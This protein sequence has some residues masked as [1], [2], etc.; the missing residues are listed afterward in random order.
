MGK[1]HYTRFP[2][3]EF[4]LTMEHSHQSFYDLRAIV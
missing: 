1:L 4:I 2:N 3:D